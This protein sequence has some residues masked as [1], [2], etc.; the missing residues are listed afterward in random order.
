ML[1]RHARL[2]PRRVGLGRMLE[3]RHANLPSDRQTSA[4]SRR[5]AAVDGERQSESHIELERLPISVLGGPHRENVS[6]LA[7]EAHR[8]RQAVA[9]VA[10]VLVDLRQSHDVSQD[11]ADARHRP[12][13]AG[14]PNGGYSGHQ[15]MTSTITRRS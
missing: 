15:Q 8:H 11:R 2:Y 9:I 10:G 6:N 14:P 7:S 1:H 4:A 13:T 3:N 12:G 5:R